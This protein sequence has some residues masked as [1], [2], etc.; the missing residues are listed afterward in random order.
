MPPASHSKYEIAFCWCLLI[1]PIAIIIAFDF[2]SV[3]ILLWAKDVLRAFG[4]CNFDE[5]HFLQLTAERH[6]NRTIQ[7]NRRKRI[8]NEHIIHRDRPHGHEHQPTEPNAP[9]F[10]PVDCRMDHASNAHILMSEIYGRP[11]LMC[12][13]RLWKSTCGERH[14]SQS[15]LCAPYAMP[16]HAMPCIHSFA[17]SE[18]RKSLQ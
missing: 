7:L 14:H 17:Q 10:L 3:F 13:T 16:C 1:S 8:F 6:S 2:E 11:A 9:G 4:E 5:R 15:A 18:Q 12:T